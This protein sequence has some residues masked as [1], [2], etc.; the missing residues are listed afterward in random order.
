[1]TSTV[2]TPA[3]SGAT[4]GAATAGPADALLDCALRLFRTPFGGVLVLEAEGDAPIFIDGRETPPR[5][6]RDMA[7]APRGDLGVS[8]WRGQRETLLR[9]LE[10]ERQFAGAYVSGRLR[11][12]GDMSLAARVCIGG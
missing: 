6:G 10:S 11:I 4:D 9:A 8:F 2:P 1:M 3:P 5:V 7:A 12:A